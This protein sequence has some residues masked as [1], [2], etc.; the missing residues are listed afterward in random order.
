MIG[1]RLRIAF[2][3]VQA[4]EESLPRIVDIM[5]E[6]LNWDKKEKKVNHRNKGCYSCQ[7]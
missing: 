1:R 2:L 7:I 6:E 5:A 4:A 3:N